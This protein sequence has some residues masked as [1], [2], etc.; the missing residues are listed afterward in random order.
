[1]T[2]SSKIH[3]FKE[4]GFNSKRGTFALLS[5]TDYVSAW[6]RDEECQ[7]SSGK[8]WVVTDRQVLFRPSVNKRSSLDWPQRRTDRNSTKPVLSENRSNTSVPLGINDSIC[9]PSIIWHNN[10]SKYIIIEGCQRINVFYFGNKHFG[11]APVFI[12]HKTDN[13]KIN[14]WGLYGIY[15]AA[16]NHYLVTFYFICIISKEKKRGG[17]GWILVDL[18]IT[19]SI[20]LHKS[21]WLTSNAILREIKRQ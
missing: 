16:G 14:N 17:Q 10:G 20:S 15:V 18:S 19:H 6:R 5:S 7:N 13:Y 8:H 1:M 4:K 12:F 21:H 9:N 11:I 3:N 2:R